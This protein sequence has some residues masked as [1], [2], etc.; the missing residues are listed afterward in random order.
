MTD[1]QKEII[2]KMRKQNETYATISDVVGIPT[3]TIKS[4]CHRHNRTL[5]NANSVYVRAAERISSLN[6]K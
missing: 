4:Y 6:P 5:K 2:R 1:E 3:G